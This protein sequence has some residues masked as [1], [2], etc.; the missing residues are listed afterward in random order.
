MKKQRIIEINYADEYIKPNKFMDIEFVSVIP[1]QFFHHLF[2]I[3]KTR[4]KVNFN[5]GTFKK[6]L[7][8]AI[9]I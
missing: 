2:F 6:L 3:W 9:L 7:N 1:C 8:S 4:T 5:P